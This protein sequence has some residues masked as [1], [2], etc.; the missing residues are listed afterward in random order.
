MK[1]PRAHI[2]FPLGVLALFAIAA[3]SWYAAAHSHLFRETADA[4]PALPTVVRNGKTITTPGKTR[5]V[6]RL[7][8]VHVPART[9]T[10]NGKV[11]T[12]P[13]HTV[14]RFVPVTV[15]GPTRTIAGP[16]RTVKGLGGTSTVIQT[17]S[18]PTVT[19]PTTTVPG[20]TTTVQGP[21]S[22]VFSTVVSTVISTVFVTTTPPPT[23]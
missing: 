8:K 23:T 21:P 6:L 7:R 22:T 9:V 13:G 12:I 4:G 17:V 1:H 19:G 5:T 14:N 20:P 11:V 18:G 3:G 16:V 10:R 2:F 15:T